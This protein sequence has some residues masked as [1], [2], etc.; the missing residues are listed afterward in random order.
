MLRRQSARVLV[1]ASWLVSACLGG[2]SGEPASDTCPSNAVPWQQSVDGV[3]P[4]QLAVTYQGEHPAKLH[5]SKNAGAVTEPVTL[6]LDYRSQ[7]GRS[8]NG[9]L[10]VSVDFSLRANDGTIIDSGQGSLSVASGGLERALY[11][12]RGQ[13][14]RVVGTFS[15]AM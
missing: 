12:G 10:S 4:E 7:S 2:Q 14:F 11:S 15:A 9:Q 8:C 13:H 1:L 6:T 3:S 5:W